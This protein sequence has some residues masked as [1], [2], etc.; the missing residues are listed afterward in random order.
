MDHPVRLGVRMRSRTMRE[1]AMDLY[2][3][4]Y[5]CQEIGAMPGMPSYAT[6]A[7]WARALGINRPRGRR[8]KEEA[9]EEKKGKKPRLPEVVGDEPAYA[10]FDGD[11]DEQLRQLQ[12]ENGMLRGMAGV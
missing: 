4:G 2:A 7:R 12:L 5:T 11:R 8:R 3:S 6:V 10:G 9:V 1:W